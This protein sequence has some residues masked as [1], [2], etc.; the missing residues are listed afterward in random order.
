LLA[1][2]PFVEDLLVVALLAVAAR[3]A[4]LRARVDAALPAARGPERLV[5]LLL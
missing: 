1:E 5:R 3:G 4:V 2:A